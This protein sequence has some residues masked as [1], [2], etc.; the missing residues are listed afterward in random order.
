[1]GRVVYLMFLPFPDRLKHIP[2]I[3]GFDWHLQHLFINI[4]ISM[5]SSN[6]GDNRKQVRVLRALLSNYSQNTQ[7]QLTPVLFIFHYK[8]IS[9]EV[10]TFL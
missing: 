6:D 7:S 3:V 1:M 9:D 8:P 10:G 4:N 2:R 5:F